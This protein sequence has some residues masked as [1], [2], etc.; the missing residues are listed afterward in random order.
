[1]TRR[2]ILHIGT[3]KTGTTTL[4]HFLSTNR[5]ELAA[6]GF[7]YPR[8][9]GAVNHTGLA[10]FAL[11]PAR[12]DPIQEPFGVRAEADVAPFRARLREAARLELADGTTTIFSNEHCH[13]RLRHAG[14]V[15]CLQALLDEFFDDVQIRVYL[16]RQDQLAVSS[17]STHLKAGGYRA[18]SCPAPRPRIPYFNYDRSLSLWEFAFGASNVRV[19]LFERPS[20]VGGSIVTDFVDVW[21]LGGM[22]GLAPVAD[23]NELIQPIAQE[24]LRLV[25]PTL[26]RLGN[27]PL[28]VVRGPLAARLD[29]MCP[30]RGTHPARAAAKAF[31]DRYRVS[32]EAV[33]QRHFPDRATL[34]GD[35]FDGYPEVEDSREVTLEAFAALAAR[36][37]MV[38]NAEIRRLEA[39]IA[40]REARLNWARDEKAAAE[41]ALRRALNWRPEHAEACR[42]LAEYLMRQDRLDEAIDAISRAT[43]IRPAYHEYW[44]F[45]GVLRRRTGAFAEAADAQ[46][47]ALDL[48]PTHAAS[49]QELAQVELRLAELERPR[50]VRQA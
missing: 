34:F 3:E 20:L 26:E 48:N 23:R 17:Y 45:L 4:Q 16:R 30:G 18:A 47:R 39:E 28:E 10:V 50:K 49:R 46:R 35:D 15:A 12:R 9:C 19:R 6:R 44:H 27:L 7:L 1:M 11:D 31:F 40:L 36:L 13:S 43:E 14:E 8:F 2:A 33:R 32:N 21:A 22:E 38:S 37:Y 29:E 5:K 25:N 41:A 42:T 24:F